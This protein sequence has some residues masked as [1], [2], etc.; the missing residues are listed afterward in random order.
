MAVLALGA[1]NPPAVV[2]AAELPGAGEGA[3]GTGFVLDGIAPGDHA[4]TA[5]GGAGDTDGDGLAEVLVGAAQAG[6]EQ[7]AEQAGEGYLVPGG[8]F[9]GLPLRRGD[10]GDDLLTG[11][12]GAERIS[13]GRGNDILD[14]EGGRDVLLG[15]AGDDSISVA[16]LAFLRV[17][18]GS[19]T[20][21]L[22][23]AGS[24]L[25]LDLTA[26]AGTRVQN[27]EVIDLGG[28]G[29]TLTLDPAAI[30]KL[31][32]DHAP[33][34]RRRLLVYGDASNAIDAGGGWQLA[35]SGGGFTSYVQDNL[36]L[37]VATAIDRNNVLAGPLR[38][39]PRG[40]KAASAPPPTG[41]GP[42]SLHVPGSG[43]PATLA[44]TGAHIRHRPGQQVGEVTL[45]RGR[46]A[47]VLREGR[48]VLRRQS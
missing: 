7:R 3:T 31:G 15:G 29:N 25:A 16:D 12:A 43:A 41:T 44:V 37:R 48:L 24:G 19:G 18:G 26:W 38:P 21:V 40:A 27:I 36:E 10:D 45:P 47:I 2:D 5:V 6:R 11:T 22:T 32:G 33:S 17:D 14:G 1:E 46:F 8:N 34:G 28:R 39:K 20:N 23:L 13:G 42:T 30:S 35:G 9:S 4:G